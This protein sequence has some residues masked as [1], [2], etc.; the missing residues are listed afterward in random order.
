MRCRVSWVDSRKQHELLAPL[1]DDRLVDQQ[2]GRQVGG[3]PPT[4]LTQPPSELLHPVP[5]RNV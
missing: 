1:F 2:H 3:G 5:H 4:G